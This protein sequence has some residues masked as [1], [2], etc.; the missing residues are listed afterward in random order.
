M[1]STRRSTFPMILLLVMASLMHRGAAMHSV[2]REEITVPR[3]ESN[4]MIDAADTSSM[5]PQ[6]NTSNRLRGSRHLKGGFDDYFKFDGDWSS[7]E[8]G[9]AGGLLCL[10]FVLFFLYCCCGCSL[11]EILMLF[12][13]YRLCCE[14][15]C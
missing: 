15:G 5:P 11:C 2:E 7:A 8:A 14:D 9:V 10:L 6:P 12:C 4:D 3:I 13:C 1:V